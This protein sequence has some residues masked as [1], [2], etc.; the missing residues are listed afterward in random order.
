MQHTQSLHFQLDFVGVLE[1]AQA[2]VVGAGGDDVSGLQFVYGTDPLDDPR[3]LM[4]H[5]VGVERLLQVF[6]DP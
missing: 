1:R 3:N 6:V 2:P 5:I 4:G